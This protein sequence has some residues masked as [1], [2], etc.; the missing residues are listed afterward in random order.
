MLK[1]IEIG[2]NRLVW[3]EAKIIQRLSGKNF[4]DAAGVKCN[5]FRELK[6]LNVPKRCQ[7]I[8]KAVM[9]S[10]EGFW[11]RVGNCFQMT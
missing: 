2:E 8:P 1:D 9:P 7:V 11:L 6:C 10:D 4:K 3:C 5:R